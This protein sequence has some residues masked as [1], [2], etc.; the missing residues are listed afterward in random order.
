M[1]D[2]FTFDV[3]QIVLLGQ[4]SDWEVVL[5]FGLISAGIISRYK[6]T[7]NLLTYLID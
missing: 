2:K 3:I 4:F 5:H 1:A 6:I 7:Y